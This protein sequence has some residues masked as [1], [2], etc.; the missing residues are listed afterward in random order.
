MLIIKGELL[1]LC[2]ILLKLVKTIKVVLQ[3]LQIY[4]NK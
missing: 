3:V 2:Q 1:I 4:L